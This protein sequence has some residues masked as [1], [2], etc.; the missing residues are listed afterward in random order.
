MCNGEISRMRCD[1][2]FSCYEMLLLKKIDCKIVQTYEH[3]HANT[4]HSLNCS[5]KVSENHLW[6]I[7]C[8]WWWKSPGKQNDNANVN[9]LIF[10]INRIGTWFFELWLFHSG[11]SRARSHTTLCDFEKSVWL[12]DTLLHKTKQ[13]HTVLTVVAPNCIHLFIAKSEK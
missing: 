2:F 9:A 4:S 1:A 7:K 8:R 11:R 10:H 3:R 13:L 6:I 12:I 5:L